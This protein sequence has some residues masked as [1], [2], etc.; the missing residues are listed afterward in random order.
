MSNK[1]V[2]IAC[3]FPDEAQARKIARLALEARLVA[4]VQIAPIDS[5]YH[6]QGKIEASPEWLASFKTL[7]H[8]AEGLTALIRAEHSY[9]V[10]EII[11]SELQVLNP[12]YLAWMQ[13]E[14]G[15]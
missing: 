1:A 7:A 3:S 2:L 13:A 10:P 5:L 11:L 6:W 4:C 15:D 8:K 14:L 9:Q 12:D